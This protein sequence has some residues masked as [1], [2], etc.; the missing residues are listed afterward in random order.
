V[1][2]TIMQWKKLLITSSWIAPSRELLE[3]TQLSLPFGL[4]CL[5]G[6]QAFRRSAWLSFLH[7][8]SNSNVLDH[9]DICIT[10]NESIF[11]W[12]YQAW[13]FARHPLLESYPF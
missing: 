10:R 8:C 2:S 5:R 4:Q 12:C 7:E 9:P 1:F 11:K 13:R 3:C 6:C